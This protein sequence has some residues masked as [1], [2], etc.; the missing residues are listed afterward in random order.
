MQLE[1]KVGRYLW[2]VI[3]CCFVLAALTGVLYRLGM[4]MPL[5]AD[6]S[7]QNIRHAHSHL[8]FF[9]WASALPLLLMYG[10][11]KSIEKKENS[12][13][14]LIYSSLW[15][16]LC[17]GL[18]S[19]PFFL[20]FGY[21]PVTVGST[22]LPLSVIFSGLVMVGWYLF[23]AGYLSM[24]KHIGEE[25]RNGWFEASLVM[26]FISSLGAWGVA[27]AQ[28]SGVSN[29]LVGKALTHFFL[30]CFTEGWV[31]LAAVALLDELLEINTGSLPFS[32]QVL[33]VLILLGAPLTFPY[34][35]SETLVTP[36]ML[37]TARSGGLIS[38]A[39]L[40]LAMY[41]LLRNGKR[42][43][44][45]FRWPIWLLLIKG[46]MQ[47]AASVMPSGFWLSDHALRIFYLHILLLGG[48][49]LV[50][51]GYLFQ[52]RTLGT[53]VFSGVVLSVIL[54]LASLLLL[55]RLWPIA[56]SGMWVYYV[57][58]A[59]AVLPALAVGAVWWK[60]TTQSPAKR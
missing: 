41:A 49:T 13:L 33:M 23:M 2:Q 52:G 10:E 51:I 31:V 46:V 54:V 37:I 24:R 7:L 50:G 38:G 20:L 12:G 59:V 11:I 9:G 53:S 15:A 57:V 55:T 18:L 30:A 5:P 58:T 28:F 29:P 17:F 3:L 44:S 60:L 6:L 32:S 43:N 4:I 40:C 47:V 1:K 19:Y 27:V 26:L 39:A 21:R 48:F 45:I 36:E 35:I 34:G 8:M 56:W 16:I 22:S 25:D 14:S 42:L